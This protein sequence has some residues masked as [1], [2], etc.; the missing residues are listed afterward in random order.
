ML[1]QVHG[2]VENKINFV[3]G[4]MVYADFNVMH[5]GANLE[6]QMCLMWQSSKV[7]SLSMSDY[8]LVDSLWEIVTY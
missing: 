2:Y 6:W 7:S 4:L 3:M 1:Q 5:A 8:K